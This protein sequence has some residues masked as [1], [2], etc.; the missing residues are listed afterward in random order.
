MHL[1]IHQANHQMKRVV[2]VILG[3]LTFLM[4]MCS[5]GHSTVFSYRNNETSQPNCHDSLKLTDYRILNRSGSN[6]KKVTA[7]TDIFPANTKVHASYSVASR[8]SVD[9]PFFLSIWRR[10]RQRFLQTSFWILFLASYGAIAYLA[11]KA[12]VRNRQL[13]SLN[14]T[15]N[16]QI[17]QLQTDKEEAQ[18]ANQSKSL[19]LA[20]MS[21][22]LRTPL[23]TILNF[24][25]LLMLDKF[26]LGEKELYLVKRI[27]ENGEYLL[28]LTNQILDLSKIEAGKMTLNLGKTTL[29]SLCESIDLMLR[30]SAE[31]KGLD[32]KIIPESDI[33][34]LLYTDGIKLQQILVNLLSNAIKFTT[35][36]SVI[37]TVKKLHSLDRLRFTVLDTG[38]GIAPE[39]LTTLFDAFVQTQ[40]G[41]HSQKGTGLGLTIS[42]K[43]VELLG[44]ELKVDSVL[45]QGTRFTFDIPANIKRNEAVTRHTWT[46]TVRVR[47][48]AGQPQ[49]RILVVDDYI[50]NREILAV[51]L[52]AW[53]FTVYE[54]IDGKDAIAKWKTWQPHLIFMDLKMP[55]L[56]GHQATQIIKSL[57]TDAPKIVAV[58]ASVFA[59][60]RA[61]TFATGCD[62]CISKPYRATTII[63]ALTRHLG[64]EF[65]ASDCRAAHSDFL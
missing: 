36:G 10:I 49:Y 26:E 53:G 23:N 63:A 17:D 56:D 45:D 25:K 22:E 28:N 47:L 13:S 46:E 16:Q 12:R 43:L 37:L 7:H 2:T 20:N 30:P 65:C 24:P 3:G 11:Y 51:L 62:D 44:G 38:V 21:H 59:Q 39:E 33:P 27:Q 52:A 34:S 4:V 29:K 61:V 8:L 14:R 32:L 60:D 18:M 58:T 54:A 9:S 35:V 41:L 5:S 6:Q 1:R 15:L 42:Y 40:S 19:F 31:R 55:K 50:S 64:V 57:S 48:A